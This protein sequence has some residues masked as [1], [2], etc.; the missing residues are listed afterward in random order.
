MDANI[1]KWSKNKFKEI[2]E[3][4][5]SIGFTKPSDK[6]LKD[7]FIASKKL[8]LIRKQIETLEAEAE[9]IQGKCKHNIFYDEGGYMYD[10]RCCAVC[11]ECIGLI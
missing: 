7:A 8:S 4:N 9:K 11:D 6:E 2:E 10:M 5:G 1:K 3:K